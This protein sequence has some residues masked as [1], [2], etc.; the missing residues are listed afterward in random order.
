M[1]SLGVIFRPGAQAD[2]DKEMSFYADEG[3]GGAVPHFLQ[4]VQDAAGRISLFPLAA[5]RYSGSV[6]RLKL[7]T[8]P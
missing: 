6:R 1:A 3:V 5:P 8:F 2:I 4:A 7:D